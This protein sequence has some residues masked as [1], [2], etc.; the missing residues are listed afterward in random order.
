MSRVSQ[1][2]GLSPSISKGSSSGIDLGKDSGIDLGKNSGVDMGQKSQPSVGASGVGITQEVANIGGT[3]VTGGVSVDVSPLNFDVSTDPSEGSISVAAGAEIPGGILGVSGGVT[4]DTNTGEVI[5]GS[6]GGEVGGFG[7]NVSNSKK[8]GVGIEFTY[9]IPGT[10][11]E[12]SLGFGFTS[13]EPTPGTETETPGSETNWEEPILP[14]GRP[15]VF[16]TVVYVT[17]SELQITDIRNLDPPY[18]ATYTACY[19]YSY[20]QWSAT[21]K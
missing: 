20:C 13:K 3:T 7:I 11:I 15:G 12:L 16:C 17:K 21:C 14:P 5:G 9:Q 2:S 18:K 10:P 4:I 1:K 6:I 8:G 19:F